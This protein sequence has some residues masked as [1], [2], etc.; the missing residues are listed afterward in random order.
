VSR[1]GRRY[2]IVSGVG[3]PRVVQIARIRIHR[4]RE[5]CGRSARR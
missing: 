2:R 3:D 4:A 1:R 5:P